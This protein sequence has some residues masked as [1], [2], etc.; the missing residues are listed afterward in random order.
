[1]YVTHAIYVHLTKYSI[2]AHIQGKEQLPWP[3]KTVFRPKHLSWCF[4]ASCVALAIHINHWD[5][6]KRVHSLGAPD[7]MFDGAHPQYLFFHNRVCVFVFVFVHSLGAS[8]RCFIVHTLA[9]PL[10]TNLKKNL[11]FRC[12][13]LLPPPP[14]QISDQILQAANKSTFVG[15]VLVS[16]GLT[17]PPVRQRQWA[18]HQW[19]VKEKDSL[20]LPL[21]ATLQNVNTKKKKKRNTKRKRKTQ[22]L[23]PLKS[24]LLATALS[25]YILHQKP[26]NPPTGKLPPTKVLLYQT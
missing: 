14:L 11:V 23:L 4:I 9:P 5:H 18:L 1:M 19:G 2:K 16:Q 8:N 6:Q 26:A 24:T 21:R 20:L 22:V 17:C 13:S 15:S 7:K 3:Y 10:I 25:V 12:Y